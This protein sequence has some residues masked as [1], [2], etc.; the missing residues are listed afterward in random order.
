MTNAEQEL[1]AARGDDPAGF[2]AAL[3][4]VEHELA[5]V[6][7][8]REAT[9]A[10]RNEARAALACVEQERDQHRELARTLGRA[11]TGMEAELV[12][13]R[14]ELQQLR[15][16]QEIR[17]RVIRERNAQLREIRRLLGIEMTLP[18]RGATDALRELL[19]RVAPPTTDRQEPT[20]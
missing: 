13:A 12:S 3:R 2:A 6:L 4:R 9:L 7:N 17:A 1:E 11:L 19:A 8:D 18:P 5:A 10:E 16:H 14:A 20:T 15:E